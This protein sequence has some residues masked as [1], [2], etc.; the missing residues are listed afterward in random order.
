MTPE[1]REELAQLMVPWLKG[2]IRVSDGGNESASAPA[3]ATQED[4][5]IIVTAVF[6]ERT[7]NF[8]WR[9]R[10]VLSQTGVVV[11]VAEKDYGEKTLG[12]VWTVEVPLGVDA[13]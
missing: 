9:K 6:D 13:P 11:D 2:T 10:E 3:E 1:G 5:T 4:G 8:A 12:H 7:A